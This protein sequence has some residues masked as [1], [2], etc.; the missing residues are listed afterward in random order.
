MRRMWA[1]LVVLAVVCC[2]R[3][4][5]AAVGTAWVSGPSPFADCAARALD[6]KLP[7]GAVEP[8]VAVSPRDARTVVAAW[9]QDRFRGVVAAASHDGGRSWRTVP[10]PGLTRCT[11]GTF[12]Y[13]DN[14]GVSIG[15]D[16]VAHL[17][18]H[19][20]GDGVASAR[21]SARSTDSGRS[22]SR[23]VVV[24]SEDRPGSGRFSGGAITAD[25]LDPESVYSIV[26]KFTQPSLDGVAYRGQVY[27][28]RSRDGGRGW[29]PPV[30]AYDTGPG[31]LTTGHQLL[32][33]ADRT[34][35]DVFTLIRR[36][37]ETGQTAQVS[38]IRSTD[39]GAHWS[40]PAPVADLRSR[41][42][43][44]PQ[45]RH[46]VNTGSS[47]VARR[48][49]R[50]VDRPDCR[51]LAGRAFHRWR[52]RFDRAVHLGRRW[53]QLVGPGPGQRDTDHDPGGRP[54]GVRAG[55]RGRRRW[56]AGGQQLRL[57]AQRRRRT[58]VDRPVAGALRPCRVCRDAVDRDLVRHPSGNRHRRRATGVLPRQHPRPHGH[59]PRIPRRLRPTRRHRTS[60]R[61]GHRRPV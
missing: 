25:P 10:L 52:R 16:G 47:M 11:G 45:T 48:R 35:L 18:A 33:L 39:L 27:L 7:A 54:A 29:Q 37:G 32:V 34:L 9:T 46:P 61:R 57:P 51:G 14:V 6:A 38:V 36:P 30:P 17:S 4:A 43:Y 40:P 41:G 26:P 50:P 15:P 21:V 53:S 60:P 20:F 55:R 56:D 12:D 8:S 28:G 2:A 3:P 24:V 22:W 19:V 58:A 49:G 13:V 5:A 1:G 42:A 31:A 59:R 44:D 23:P